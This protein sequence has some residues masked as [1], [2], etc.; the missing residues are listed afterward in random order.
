MS[1]YYTL[2]FNLWLIADLH[3]ISFF[4]FDQ[5]ANDFEQEH[6][7]IV[8]KKL[9]LLF[10]FILSGDAAVSVEYYLSFQFASNHR[11]QKAKSYI[12]IH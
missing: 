1:Y 2:E 4:Y 12:Y 6:C 10:L 5:Y 8:L 7:S 9:G 3:F 11:K